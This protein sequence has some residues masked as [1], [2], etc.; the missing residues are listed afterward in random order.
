MRKL[1]H[2]NIVKFCEIYSTPKNFYIVQE[3][4]TGKSLNKYFDENNKIKEEISRDIFFQMCLGV[5]FIHHHR[6]C[7]RDLKLENILFSDSKNMQI[8]IIDF[9]LGKSN[10]DE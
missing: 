2:P 10:F 5:S 3:L 6:V 7:H 8:K 1:D 4:L 9:G